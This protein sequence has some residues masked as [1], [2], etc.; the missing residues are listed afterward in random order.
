MTI[1][2]YID[3]VGRFEKV[4]M[5]RVGNDWKFKGFIRDPQP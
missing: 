4:S 5:Q 3:G 2:V 1:G